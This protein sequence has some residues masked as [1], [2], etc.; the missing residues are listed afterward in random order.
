MPA[1]AALEELGQHRLTKEGFDLA[2]ITLALYY[3]MSLL[4]QRLRRVQKL[5]EDQ[6]GCLVPADYPE[7]WQRRQGQPGSGAP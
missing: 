6:A 4:M 7:C 5:R 1:G 2:L 3:E